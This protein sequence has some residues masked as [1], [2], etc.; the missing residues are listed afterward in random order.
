MRDHDHIDN[1]GTRPGRVA[2]LALFIAIINVAA[3]VIAERAI[4]RTGRVSVA[5]AAQIVRPAIVRDDEA[6]ANL[7]PSTIAPAS[8]QSPWRSG[9][10][11]K[12]P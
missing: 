8:H 7:A 1:I 9:G 3:G 10:A 11:N 4:S 12:R 2:Q 6:P 5:S